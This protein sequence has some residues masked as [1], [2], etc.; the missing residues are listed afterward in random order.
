M[1]D[2]KEKRKYELKKR[3]S[4]E[5][6]TLLEE[7]EKEMVELVGKI[8]A[9]IV[10]YQAKIE[11]DKKILKEMESKVTQKVEETVIDRD[12]KDEVKAVLRD[13][14]QNMIQLEDQ[15]S[16]GRARQEQKLREKLERRKLQKE[17][18]VVNISWKI[19]KIFFF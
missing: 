6:K 16:E 10:R 14:Q 8:Q 18:C 1:E 7:K 5:T 17:E 3:L 2:E 19:I 11:K 12:D 9:S 4:D 13:Y 15:M